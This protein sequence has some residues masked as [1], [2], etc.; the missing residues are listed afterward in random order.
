MHLIL[1]KKI[2]FINFF[3]YK[4]YTYITFVSLLFTTLLASLVFAYKFSLLFPE[5]ISGNLIQLEKIPF[6][7]GNLVNNLLN[8]SSY[9]IQKHGIDWYLDRLPFVAFTTIL[10]SKIS[11]NI[12]I[13]LTIKN[14]FFF[15]IFFYI[16][17]KTKNLFNN[18]AYFF[19]IL[20]HVI[21]INFYN[22][23]T[24]LNFVF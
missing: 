2:N 5:I 20:T 1:K 23:Q 21:F 11:T 22:F 3:F 15:F 7:I 19:F 4:Y 9:K 16:C 24:T 10:I 8:N 6:N 14:C 13:F 17:N 18:N 12:Y